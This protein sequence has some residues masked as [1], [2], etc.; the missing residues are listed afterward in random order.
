LA[1][2]WCRRCAARNY[3][4]GRVESGRPKHLQTKTRHV[5][6]RCP[7]MG[8]D[9]SV[10]T[11]VSSTLHSLSASRAGSGR[12]FQYRRGMQPLLEWHWGCTPKA[13]KEQAFACSFSRKFLSVLP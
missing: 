7:A 13:E 4:G 10:H 5:R 8:C 9:G 11:K 6:G 2:D 1:I 3:C 12:L